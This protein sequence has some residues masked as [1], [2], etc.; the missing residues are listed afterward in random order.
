MSYPL[1]SIITV[2]NEVLC[3]EVGGETVLLDL[4]GENYFSLNTVGSRIWQLMQEPEELQIVFDTILAEFDVD[5]GQL[6]NDLDELLDDLIAR[7]LVSIES[8]ND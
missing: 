3:Q 2:S 5:E 7:S 8:N 1:S 4:N 6:K